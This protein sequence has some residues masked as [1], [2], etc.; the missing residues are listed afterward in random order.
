M[1]SELVTAANKQGFDSLVEIERAL[2]APGG[3]LWFF[4]R[5]PTPEDQ[6]QKDLIERLDRI[7]K[8]LERLP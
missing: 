4:R 8:Q 6:R 7:E 2:L 5:T 3:A 1:K